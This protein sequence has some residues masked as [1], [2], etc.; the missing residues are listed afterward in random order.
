MVLS[1]RQTARQIGSSFAITLVFSAMS[2]VT[3]FT[4]ASNLE[5]AEG[6]TASSINIAGI[7]GGFAAVVFLS[8][9]AFLLTFFLKDPKK[10]T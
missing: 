2:I 3:S 10:E 8:F 5:A 1:A 7:R 4:A 9:G 6:E